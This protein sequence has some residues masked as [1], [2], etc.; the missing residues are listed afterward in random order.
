MPRVRAHGEAGRVVSDKELEV[1]RMLADG[2][3]M[4]QISARLGI[5]ME[6][7]S[8]RL[9]RAADV[10]GTR[11]SVQTVVVS[12]RHGLLG[13]D[14]HRAT[15]VRRELADRHSSTCALLRSPT[16]DCGGLH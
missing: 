2:L 11:T 15:R 1:V 9:R 14:T 16:C 3:Q 6:A 13:P 7:V 12:L 8:M 10:L 4:K 5:S